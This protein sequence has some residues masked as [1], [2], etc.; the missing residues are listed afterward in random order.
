MLGHHLGRN[1][2][3]TTT[4]SFGKSNF[5][6]AQGHLGLFPCFVLPHGRKAK[7]TECVERGSRVV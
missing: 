1:G 4:N 6:K 2:K 7:T 3:V 5:L